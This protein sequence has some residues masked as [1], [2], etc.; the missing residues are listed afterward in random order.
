[1]KDG[2]RFRGNF[3]MPIGYIFD[4]VP[5]E[6]SAIDL[7]TPEKVAD[8]FGYGIWKELNGVFTFARDN[9]H[10]VGSTGGE[11]EHKLIQDEIPKYNITSKS[12]TGEIWNMAGQNSSYPN[13]SCS[14]IV[15]KRTNVEGVGYAT[16]FVS[17]TQDGFVIDASH[18]HSTG[19]GD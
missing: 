9:E 13:G 19:G 12:L 5:V 3:E 16:S 1:M 15:S 8:Y 11:L 2:S 7:S 18:T 6:D 17:N 10:S 4:W 14:G